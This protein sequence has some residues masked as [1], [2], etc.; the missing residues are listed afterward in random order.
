MLGV[1]LALLALAAPH[2][3]GQSA[4]RLLDFRA[5]NGGHR[6]A[7]D[8][9]LLTTVTPSR[10]TARIAFTLTERAKVIMRVED[11]N[12][13]RHAVATESATFPAGRHAF[14]WTPSPDAS[15][16][17]YLLLLTAIDAA[18]RRRT[19]G[20]LTAYTQRYLPAPVIRTL[21]IDAYFTSQSYAPDDVASCTSPPTPRS[22]HSRSS[23]P[24]G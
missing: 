6:F 8:G 10:P 15:P 16:R 11:T 3:S 23:A 14:L 5:S 1:A 7:G 20:A 19:Y 9:P 21:G 22:S 2:H 13:V 12:R 18:G 4:P 24:R 17:T